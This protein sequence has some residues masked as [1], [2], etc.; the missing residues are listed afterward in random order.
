[1]PITSM[2]AKH[3]PPNT[4]RSVITGQVMARHRSRL[5]EARAFVQF[6]EGN[7]QGNWPERRDRGYSIPPKRTDVGK[8]HAHACIILGQCL[9]S[10][11]V[12]ARKRR[13][14]SQHKSWTTHLKEL[15]KWKREQCIG[16]KL[17]NV[18]VD[19]NM[20]EIDDE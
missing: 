16:G 18:I 4:K 8:M 15:R 10:S 5:S 19:V 2:L 17:A 14:S 13:R 20:N 11:Q 3:V 7:I 1:M 9:P 12:P 6:I